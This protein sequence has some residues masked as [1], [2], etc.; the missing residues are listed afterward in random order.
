[1]ERSDNIFTSVTDIPFTA[2]I[3]TW[4]EVQ[5]WREQKT[6]NR[7]TIHEFTWFLVVLF[8]YQFVYRG[9]LSVVC[10]KQNNIMAFF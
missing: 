2:K 9:N 4:K 1:M 6:T 3:Y 8:V 7:N 5:R 10:R